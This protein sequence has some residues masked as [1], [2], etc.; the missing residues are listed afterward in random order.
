MRLWV[1]EKHNWVIYFIALHVRAR[2]PAC[3]FIVAAKRGDS[4]FSLGRVGVVIIGHNSDMCLCT[5]LLVLIQL[6][7]ED[8]HVGVYLLDYELGSQFWI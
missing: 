8:V 5:F 4:D 7:V 3:L 6:V 1:H 2:I